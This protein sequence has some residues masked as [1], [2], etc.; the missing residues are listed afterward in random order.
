MALSLAHLTAGSSPVGCSLLSGLS[1]PFT[2]G[3]S[4]VGNSSPK[5]AGVLPTHKPDF[6]RGYHLSAMNIT[7]HLFLP[8]LDG[9]RVERDRTSSSQTNPLHGISAPK[10]YPNP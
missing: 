8:T 10:V 6:V 5:R 1:S 9:S 3:D 7:V 2:E 4:A